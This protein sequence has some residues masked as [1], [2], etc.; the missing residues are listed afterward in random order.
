MERDALLGHG[1]SAMLLDRM[2]Y[3]SDPFYV[4]ICAACGALANS[5][6]CP[7]CGS[8]DIV[9]VRLAY[10]FKLLLSIINALN[11]RVNIYPMRGIARSE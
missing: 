8:V 10:A 6:A 1:I 11:I 5:H 3:A 9:R 2:F 7:K 4:A